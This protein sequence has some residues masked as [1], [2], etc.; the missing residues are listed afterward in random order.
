MFYLLR[1]KNAAAFPVRDLA[2]KEFIFL[3]LFHVSS[4][5]LV[6]FLPLD[7]RAIEVPDDN[8]PL[9]KATAALDG[10]VPI[11]ADIKCCLL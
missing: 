1:T 8:D 9:A 11:V 5:L 3:D 2:T 6:L 4:F 7:P 10:A